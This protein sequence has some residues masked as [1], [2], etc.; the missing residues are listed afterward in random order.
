MHALLL[1]ASLAHF[2]LELLVDA[3]RDIDRRRQAREAA[4]RRPRDRRRR[5]GR[6]GSRILWPPSA[7]L[8]WRPALGDERTATASARLEDGRGAAL[9]LHGPSPP[10]SPGHTWRR[11]HRRAARARSRSGAL[12]SVGCARRARQMPP[13]RSPTRQLPTTF[14]KTLNGSS[15]TTS[16]FLAL[17][18]HQGGPTTLT[19]ATGTSVGSPTVLL[20][21]HETSRDAARGTAVLPFTPLYGK[22]ICALSRGSY[23]FLEEEDFVLT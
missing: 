23:E 3:F 1:A 21:K 6:R 18:L 8:Y 12:G 20:H 2:N 22:H 14:E 4:D 11:Q 5:A 17:I 10:P 16:S 7:A 19:R 13:H 15:S 9:Q